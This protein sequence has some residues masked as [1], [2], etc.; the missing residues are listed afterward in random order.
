MKRLYD[1]YFLEIY[2]VIVIFLLFF[3]NLETLLETIS[4]ARY[5]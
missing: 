4:Y 2:Y 3:D 5:S 1:Y